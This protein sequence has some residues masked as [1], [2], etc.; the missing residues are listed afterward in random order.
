MR[1]R[2][3]KIVAL[4]APIFVGAA[5]LVSISLFG[6]GTGGVS[7][8]SV[9]ISAGET[10]ASS[11]PGSA[12]TDKAM[13]EIPEGF[14][15]TSNGA[16]SAPTPTHWVPA[17][18]I[19]RHEVT[20]AQFAIFV[21]TTGYITTAEQT[22]K[23]HVFV[24][25]QNTWAA[26]AGAD[27]RHPSG[28]DSSIAVRDEYPV[29][30]VS[31]YDA[32]AYARW[33]GKELPRDGQWLRSARRRGEI[34]PPGNTFQGWYPLKDTARDGHQ[35]LAPVASFAA[36]G[37]GLLDMHGNVREWCHNSLTTDGAS[38]AVLLGLHWLS[39]DASGS[40]TQEP[41]EVSPDWCD[42]TTGFRCVTE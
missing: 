37:Y 33:A 15:L 20:N 11:R 17:F 26:V 23:G 3:A 27:W 7:L 6:K 19:D 4:S 16:T 18:R 38:P 41:K 8:P 21:T 29:V 31:Y 25:K 34:P 35:G 30:Q 42:D 12:S 1:L 10:S 22:G 9:A 28:P 5:W 14:H 2:T 39:T 36:N 24:P 13:A 32:L 40:T